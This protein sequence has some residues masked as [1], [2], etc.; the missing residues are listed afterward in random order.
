M[1]STQ[2]RPR[3]TCSCRTA[4][5]IAKVECVFDAQK[6]LQATS[7]RHIA[8]T[9]NC[10]IP[11]RIHTCMDGPVCGDIHVLREFAFL[12]AVTAR[13]M[14]RSDARSVVP[15]RGACHL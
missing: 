15:R 3:A 7:D 14:L 1:D 10:S 6:S 4:W 5:H 2:R 9:L 8:L 11:G 13:A 12:S